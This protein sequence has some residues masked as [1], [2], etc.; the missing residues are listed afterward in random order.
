MQPEPAPATAPRSTNGLLQAVG[1]YSIW[2]FFPL[3][4]GLLAHVS[5]WEVVAHR[6][7]WSAPVLLVI[8]WLTGALGQLRDALANR[9]AIR[10]IAASAILLAI[11]WLVYIW[12]V[13][14]EHVIAA[15]L[16]YYLNPLVNVLLGYTVLGER[17]SRRQWI[18]VALAGIGV[19]V[20]AA[21]ALASLWI[22]IA[23]ALSFGLYGLV[24]KT[25]S[26]GPLAG[27]TMEVLLLLPVS[28]LFLLWWWGAGRMVFGATQDIATPLLLIAAGPLTTIPLLLFASAARKLRY[29]TIGLIQYIGPT[30]QL[31]LGVYYYGEQA[32][33]AQ[34]AALALIWAALAIYSYESLRQARIAAATADAAA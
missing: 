11:N 8:L 15:S 32:N 28:A 33:R 10:A 19:A 24:R 34:G 13:T 25:A 31:L 1:A 12:A 17:L 4:F 6:I 7:V 23:L 16:G 9:V 2:G 5:A 3:F 22:S 29:A 30:I 21:G 18:A 26:P 14:N 27:L 20:L